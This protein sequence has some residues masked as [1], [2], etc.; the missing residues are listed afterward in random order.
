M[1]ESPVKK[2]APQNDFLLQQTAVQFYLEDFLIS[3]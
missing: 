2:E 1:V 3:I